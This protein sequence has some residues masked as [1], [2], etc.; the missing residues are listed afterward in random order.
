MDR[1]IVYGN[2]PAAKT[3][4]HYLTGDSPHR[5]EAFTVDR[6]VIAEP[7]LFDLPVVPFDEVE[8]HYP[9]SEYRMLVAVSYR[10]VNRLRMA[11]Y[12][13]AKSRGYAFVNYVSSRATVCPDLLAG[14]NCLIGANAVIQ[15]SVRLGKNVVL[16]DNTFTG[17]DTVIEDHCYIGAGVVVLGRVR[18]G[19][20]CLIGANATIREGVRIGTGCIIGA[21]VALLH[22]AADNEVYM[23]RAA[24]K[25]PLTSDQL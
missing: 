18:V 6:E 4:Y 10:Q 14:E 21:G 7:R 13:Q 9:P 8:R 3:A 5:V 20:R 1:L 22:D 15:H 17:H 11:R 12:E 19:P 23:N 2:G 24:Q 25:L 16:R